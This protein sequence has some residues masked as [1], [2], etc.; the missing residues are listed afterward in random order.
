ERN[1]LVSDLGDLKSGGSNSGLFLPETDT[2]SPLK[3]SLRLS[4]HLR[5]FGSGEVEEGLG[6]LFLPPEKVFSPL[7]PLVL[8]GSNMLLIA[9]HV[10]TMGRGEQ[11]QGQDDLGG[12]ISL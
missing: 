4:S 7:P 8:A 12:L 6:E 1:V 3:G 9:F 2:N 10:M 5:G 11:S